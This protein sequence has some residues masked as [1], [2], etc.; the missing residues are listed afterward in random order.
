MKTEN[1]DA[2][3]IPKNKSI[4]KVFELD[5]CSIF[6]LL[7]S[8]IY[9]SD[10][11]LRPI[12]KESSIQSFQEVIDKNKT[13]KE[14][15]DSIHLMSLKVFFCD[16]GQILIRNQRKW[17][18]NRRENVPGAFFHE[19]IQLLTDPVSRDFSAASSNTNK[20][21]HDSTTIETKS[22]K[23]NSSFKVNESEDD[24][25]K[26][27]IRISLSQNPLPFLRHVI[28]L[29]D[30]LDTIKD[31]N[32]TNSHK[33]FSL[34]ANFSSAS[35][36]LKYSEH[37]TTETKNKQTLSQSI[38]HRRK[39]ILRASKREHIDSQASEKKLYDYLNVLESRL[40]QSKL[41]NSNN[42]YTRPE[43]NTISSNET[44][45]AHERFDSDL[46]NLSDWFVKRKREWRRQRA[47][48]KVRVADLLM[49]KITLFL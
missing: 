42:K 17:K 7:G 9:P 21:D 27:L 24:S 5:E 11:G 23:C 49:K 16:D 2:E 43:V 37:R 1:P 31:E 44:M 45:M 35:S 40:L 38:G 6:H 33:N 48:M 28:E 26:T 46:F 10:C 39:S 32:S 15:Q 36:L 3:H 13:T 30:S 34:L 29:P 18:E 22:K 12:S 19:T 25:W 8:I 4:K 14:Q 20:H 41:V 47:L